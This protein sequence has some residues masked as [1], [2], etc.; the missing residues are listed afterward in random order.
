MMMQMVGMA[1]VNLIPSATSR[2]TFPL[3]A[4]R[5]DSRKWARSL[6]Y[7]GQPRSQ[8]RREPWERGCRRVFRVLPLTRKPTDSGYVIV[9]YPRS[10]GAPDDQ[11]V[12]ASACLLV[13]S[14]FPEKKKK[15]WSHVSSYLVPRPHYLARTKRFRSRGPSEPRIRHRS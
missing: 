7:H 9:P 13:P 2:L 4:T 6:D 11:A 15:A 10:E 14:A 12:C 8:G 3:S 5:A 1:A